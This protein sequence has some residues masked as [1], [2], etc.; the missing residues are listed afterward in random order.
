LLLVLVTFVEICE[1]GD[2][3][4]EVFLEVEAEFYAFEEL[5]AK[6]VESLLLCAFDLGSCL[7]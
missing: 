7:F 1:A 3:L 6:V 4:L 2:V 5:L